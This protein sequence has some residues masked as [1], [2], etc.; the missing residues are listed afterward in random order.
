MFSDPR[1]RI[2]ESCA[3]LATVQTELD[4]AYMDR[5]KGTLSDAQ[6]A[7]I[8][9]TAPTSLKALSMLVSHGLE[10]QVGGLLEDTTITPPV[11]AGAT[12]DPNGQPFQGDLRHAVAA[13]SQNGTPMGVLVPG[14]G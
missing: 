3:V 6:Y 8:V 12:F 1:D 13:C 9:N 2:G 7:A 14:S 4:N 10:S 5:A 11:V